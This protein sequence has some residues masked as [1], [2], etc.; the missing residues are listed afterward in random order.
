MD[1]FIWDRDG[2]HSL[3]SSALIMPLAIWLGHCTCHTHCRFD[4]RLIFL[5]GSGRV[6]SWIGFALRI[7]P[8]QRGV[9]T[10]TRILQI[11]I[12]LRLVGG[13][14]MSLPQVH[15]PTFQPKGMCLHNFFYELI[16]KTDYSLE[17]HVFPKLFQLLYLFLMYLNSNFFLHQS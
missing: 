8:C 13:W 11:S 15:M 2:G 4:T 16:S 14:H 5:G 10:T 7:F 17:F 12:L 3:R 1:S 9:L 6:G